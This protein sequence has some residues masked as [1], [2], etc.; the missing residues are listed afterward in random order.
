MRDARVRQDA[1]FLTFTVLCGSLLF[2]ET[3]LASL[4]A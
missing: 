2:A 1:K 4:S 3:D